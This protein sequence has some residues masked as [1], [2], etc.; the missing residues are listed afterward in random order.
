MTGAYT[1]ASLST[2]LVST[3]DFYNL[4][5]SFGY[6]VTDNASENRACLN[7]LSKELGFSTP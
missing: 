5:E 2:Q 7:I 6:A 3:L 1:A 4:R